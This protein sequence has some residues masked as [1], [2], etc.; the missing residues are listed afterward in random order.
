MSD[1]LPM[2]PTQTL[3][4]THNFRKY[5]PK[6]QQVVN[7]PCSS[8]RGEDSAVLHTFFTDWETRLPLRGGTYLEIGGVNGLAESNTWIF[9]VCLGWQGVLVEGHPRFF[10]TLRKHRPQG[11]NLRMAA[12]PG[13]NGWVNY[14]ASRD[15][16]AGVVTASGATANRSRII[17]RPSI[18][19]GCGNLGLR[20][21]QM[22]VN[23]LDFA[24]I[25]VEGSETMVLK[26]LNM[27]DLSL[28]VVLIEVRN[29]GQRAN[30]MRHMLGRG[31][32]YVGQIYARGTSLNKV[33]DDC[34]VNISHMRRFFPRSHALRGIS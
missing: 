15:T 1:A 2:L 7:F 31:M 4:V 19:V 26:S 6:H 27:P 13:Y 11:L 20:L 10:K 32:R 25:D 22:G 5:R 24:S 8:S 34:F 9:E 21:Q 29:D 14:T 18:T 28:G 12:C 30:L 33:V 17:A 16:T 23:R 3:Y